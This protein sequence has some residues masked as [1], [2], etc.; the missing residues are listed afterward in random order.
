[1][2]VT[3]KNKIEEKRREVKRREVKRKEEERARGCSDIRAVDA[4]MR[5]ISEVNV[6]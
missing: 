3:A 5:S 4:D 1:M 6:S 2:Q